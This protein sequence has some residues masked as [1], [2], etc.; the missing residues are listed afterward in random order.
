MTTEA[1][2]GID[3]SETW[4][5]YKKLD[6]GNERDSLNQDWFS[7]GEI[8]NV[9]FKDAASIQQLHQHLDAFN[10]ALLESPDDMRYKFVALPTRLKITPQNEKDDADLI[11]LI[12][13][14]SDNVTLDDLKQFTNHLENE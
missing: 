5:Y 8:G 12:E 2:L 10:K 4:G 11:I 7:A 6:D 13:P 14:A 3:P 9:S 1:K